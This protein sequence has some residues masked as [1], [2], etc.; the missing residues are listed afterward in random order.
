M[1]RAE[2]APPDSA[3]PD[4]VSDG[5]V[6][7]ARLDGYVPLE[8]YAVLGDGRTVVMI[9]RDGRI[10][11]WPLP[12]LHSPPAFAA[13]LDRD[14]GGYLALAPRDPFSV[15]REYVEGTNVLETTFTT[16]SGVV[17]V[18]DALCVG[19][20]GLLPWVQLVRSVEGVSGS[21]PME[22]EIV[23]GDRFGQARPWT[24]RRRDD[25]LLHLGIS[26][27]VSAPSM[28]V[29]R[30]CMPTASADRSIVPRVI[31]DCSG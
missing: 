22:W 25:I 2:T 16:S 30:M 8:S 13:I 28:S 3:P 21:V 11:W 26:G 1:G 15:E 14:D 10:D 17:K 4:V 7:R 9:A 12:A 18:R 31:G 27:S 20:N 6:A 29:S 5:D 19:K 23:P 24:E